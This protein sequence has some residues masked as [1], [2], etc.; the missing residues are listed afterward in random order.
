M[1]NRHLPRSHTQDLPDQDSFHTSYFTL[2]SGNG[3]AE[4]TFFYSST[5]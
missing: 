4:H 1:V 3:F 5:L 2:A